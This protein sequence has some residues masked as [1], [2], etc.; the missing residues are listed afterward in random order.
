MMQ[1]RSLP[2]PK[3]ALAHQEMEGLTRVAAFVLLAV[4]C[5]SSGNRMQAGT[6]RLLPRKEV[7]HNREPLGDC[8]L[9]GFLT[10]RS[11]P[12][13]GSLRRMDLAT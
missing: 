1:N 13:R 4:L 11:G 8:V 5:P 7:Q 2:T 12:Q 3:S 9:Y 6:A 10:L